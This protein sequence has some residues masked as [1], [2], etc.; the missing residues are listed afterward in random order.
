MPASPDLSGQAPAPSQDKPEGSITL[1]ELLQR[2]RSAP[3][4]ITEF[5]ETRTLALL[6]EPLVTK[7][8]LFFKP[9]D[10]MVR[11]TTV[12]GHTRMVVDGDAVRF[13]DIDG[14]QDMD[15][16][17]N[18]VARQLV[19]SFMVLF[20]G[21][22]ERLRDLYEVDFEGEG[23]RWRLMLRPR[24]APLD[25]LVASLELAGDGPRMERM[26]LI[27][28]DGDST[29]T[30]FGRMDVEHHFGDGP[31]DAIVGGEALF[32]ASR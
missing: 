27:E 18:P 26:E 1:E 23:A 11:R 17:S 2:M 4:V 31:L 5:R 25:R 13:S 24:R 12:P 3:G 8:L 22:A 29:V 14:A 20:N 19:D 16:A 30:G 28:P 7:G 15:L 6:S 10:R 21:D 32:P 9:P